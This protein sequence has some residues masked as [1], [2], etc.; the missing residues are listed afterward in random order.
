MLTGKM[1]LDEFYEVGG[2]ILTEFDV[3][4]GKPAHGLARGYYRLHL[5]LILI[6]LFGALL[7]V[8]A[9]VTGLK[10][11]L[12]FV[13]SAVV[14]WK[15]FFPLLL[16]NYP[17]LLTGLLIVALLTAVVTF[18][19]GGLNRRGLATFLGSML[20]VLLTC[21]LA[22]WFVRLFH[23]HGAV[24]PFAETILYSGYYHLNITDMY[25]ASQ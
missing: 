7:L 4:D 3:V 19:V 21:G 11:M 5:Q 9:G 15:L 14:L 10:A 12:S 22:V 25:I 8:T 17:P 2:V 18:S 20:G 6:C 24:R 1:E 23:L 13:F 16:N